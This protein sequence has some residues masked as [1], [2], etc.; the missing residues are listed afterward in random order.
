MQKEIREAESAIALVMFEYMIKNGEG[1]T[2][3]EAYAMLDECEI[4][5]EVSDLMEAYAERFPQHFRQVIKSI[6]SENKIP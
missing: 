5:T 4:E 2:P 6:L 1:I 3:D